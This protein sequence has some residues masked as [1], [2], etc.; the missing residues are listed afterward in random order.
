MLAR[1]SGFVL[2]SRF[3]SRRATSP[4][5]VECD[6][7]VL[8]QLAAER[9]RTIEAA[10]SRVDANESLDEVARSRATRFMNYISRLG[11]VPAPDT[12]V[13]ARTLKTRA[14]QTVEAVRRSHIHRNVGLVAV[15][16]VV[17]RPEQ[18]DVVDDMALALQRAAKKTTVPFEVPVEPVVVKSEPAGKYA[19]IEQT[20]QWLEEAISPLDISETDAATGIVIVTSRTAHQAVVQ[21]NPRSIDSCEGWGAE[22]FRLEAPFSDDVLTLRSVNSNGVPVFSVMSTIGRS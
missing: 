17:D 2:V 3:A 18:L 10:K 16:P 22:V 7:Q 5:S 6:P 15:V 14:R 19:P 20:A 8:S 12:R 1:E 11:I 13:N 4:E 21:A 9:E